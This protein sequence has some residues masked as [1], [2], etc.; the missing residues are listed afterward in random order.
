[1]ASPKQT[2]LDTLPDLPEGGPPAL[3]VEAITRGLIALGNQEDEQ[4]VKQFMPG[5]DRAY[6]VRVPLL[7]A[8]GKVIAETYKEDPHL[9]RSIAL[10]SWPRGTREHRLVALFT[11][12]ALKLNAAD[13]WEIGL[14]F[15]HD[16]VTWDHCDQLCSTLLGYAL[17][18]DPNYM[19][20]LEAWLY[21]DNQ[22]VR[23]AALVST[24]YLRRASFA[25][26]VALSLDRR[27][28]AMCYTLLMD[29]ADYVRKA[30]DWAI[31]EVMRRH[32]DLGRDW[33]LERAG[34]QP[35]RRS[36]TILKLSAKKLSKPDREQFLTILSSEGTPS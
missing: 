2:V 14:Q 3:V 31:R 1:M 22:W 9:V 5:L 6:G 13:A 32:Y 11:L 16:V 30:V 18:L 21:D 20:Q 29:E 36:Q 24:T 26:E 23:R 19:D 28:L 34:E 7:R 12:E 10:G 25:N 15:L 27:A 4:G 33:L 35:P 8:I 17:A